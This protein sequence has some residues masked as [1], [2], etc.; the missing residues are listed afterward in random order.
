MQIDEIGKD[1]ARRRKAQGLSQEELANQLGV[2]RQAVSKWESGA[3]LPSVDNMVELAR[4]FDASVD[5]LLR[6]EH[7][8][9][10]SGLSAEGVGRMLDEQ[11]KRQEKR[12][13]K[14]SLL[15]VIVTGVL[16][17]PIVLSIV[18]VFLFTSHTEVSV[19]ER[20]QQTQTSLESRISAIDA[21]VSGAVRQ[22][23]DEGKT[24]LT[25]SGC[26][27]CDYDYAAR[28][29]QLRLFAYPQ[30]LGE[31]DG[32]EFYALLSDGSRVSVPAETVSGGF[33]A[34]L[35]IP[36]P[37]TDWLSLDVYV[38]WQ[39]S[40]D[41]VTEAIFVPGIR[42]DDLRMRI[43]DL[44]SNLTYSGDEG[45]S[46]MPYVMLSV[47]SAPDAPQPVSVLF[48]VFAGGELLADA[49]EPWEASDFSTD[50]SGVTAVEV[51][52]TVRASEEIS[53]GPEFSP[54]QLLLRATV[55]DSAGNRHTGEFG[56]K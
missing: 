26:R 36:D 44:W 39:E 52:R 6:L 48:E 42:L 50:D 38:S 24:R 19:N 41:T 10:E 33:E 3:A 2:T 23:L 30:V 13:R 34:T 12:I 46:L 31:S 40:G 4:V 53:V 11:S 43:V 32:A 35:S 8:G 15:L 22:A 7:A 21:S 51:Y 28:A 17:V 45:S 25:D 47:P 20:I 56:F 18:L 49:E 1:I 9:R 29:V 55:T 37:D 54:E 5:E 14:L 27:S 16:L